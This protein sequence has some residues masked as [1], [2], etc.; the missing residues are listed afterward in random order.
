MGN[1]RW[2]PSDWTSYTSSVSSKPTAAI[3]TSRNLHPDL[4]PKGVKIRESRD[5]A[6]NPN[7]NAIIV[8]IDVTGSMGMLADVMAKKGLGVLIEELL[9]R[10]PIVDPH[11][12]VMAN[13][14]A[15]CDS[16]PLQASQFEA[17]NELVPQLEKIFLEHGGGGNNTESYDFPWYFAAQHTS[18]DCFE[19]RGKKGYLFTIG[20]EEAPH[21]LEAEWIRRFIGDDVHQGLKAKQLL[22]M[23]QRM[24]N[25]FHVVVEEGDY[26]SGAKD[27]VYSTWHEM[28]KQN[29]LPLSDHTKLAE[30]IVSTI[31]VCEGETVDKVAASWDGD[32]SLVVQDAV[33]GV[34]AT[35]KSGKG[36]VVRLS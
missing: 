3:Y 24:Y 33:K 11:V 27:R 21:G 9:E 2:S 36:D 20:D 23:A 17:G 13:G 10:K 31:Q 14:D 6:K 22:T 18:I 35:L 5:S 15:H 1:S 12:M 34:A 25:V 29:V 28:L 26:A 8:D 4:D 7:S 16:A 30:V 19:K 32:T